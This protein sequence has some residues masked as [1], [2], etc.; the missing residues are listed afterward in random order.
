MDELKTQKCGRC[1]IL[2]RPSQFVYKE[3]TNKTCVVCCENNKKYNEKKKQND[4]YKQ[5]KIIGKKKWLEN[6]KTNNRKEYKFKQMIVNSKSSDM[7][8]PNHYDAENFIDI[9]YLNMLYDIQ[10]G[11][12]IYCKTLMLFDFNQTKDNKKIS[13]QRINNDYGHIKINC[14]F[15]CLNCNVIRQEKTHD[16]THY[17]EILNKMGVSALKN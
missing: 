11:L 6:Q 14:V 5:N 8:K 15:C 1:K 9:D 16:E 7:L 2:R 10:N 13:I 3:K 4:E 17:T 12:C